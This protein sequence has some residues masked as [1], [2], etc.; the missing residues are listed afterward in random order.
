MAAVPAD[1][2]AIPPITVVPD[3]ATTALTKIAS[4]GETVAT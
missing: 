2:F 3:A 1:V 4:P